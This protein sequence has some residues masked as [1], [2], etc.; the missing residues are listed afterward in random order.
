MEIK[1]AIRKPL[2]RYL[3]ANDTELNNWIMEPVILGRVKRIFNSGSKFDEMIVL[4]GGQGIGKSTFARYLSITDDWFCTIENIQ[5]KDA[6]MNLM[7]K[8]VVSLLLNRTK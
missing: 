3:G 7:G 5:G 8:T 6:V 2:P 4:V 1:N